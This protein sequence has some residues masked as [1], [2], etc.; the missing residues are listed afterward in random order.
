VGRENRP[1]FEQGF[2]E[3]SQAVPELGAVDRI[4]AEANAAVRFCRVELARP[5]ASRSPTVAHIG[6]LAS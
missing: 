3:M 4:E 5:E 6:A 1:A 2:R